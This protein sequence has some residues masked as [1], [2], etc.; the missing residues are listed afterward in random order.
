MTYPD[1]DPAPEAAHHE[2]RAALQTAIER[3]IAQQKAAQ[4]KLDGLNAQRESLRE[5]AARGESVTTDSLRQAE[6]KIRTAETDLL[7]HEDILRRQR[8]MVAD[9]DKV[10]G[11]ARAMAHHPRVLHA[12]PE[13]VAGTNEEQAHLVA[14]RAARK[15][16][17]EAKQVLALA[18]G[19]G[20]PVP[21]ELMP[22]P[23]MIHSGLRLPD[24]CDE[25]TVR[26]IF[27]D[28]ATEALG[29]VP[30]AQAVA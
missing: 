15:R 21:L 20:Y 6:A 7:N 25:R 26:R 3:T 17:D 10:A 5:A 8:A 9:H 1:F 16:V 2:Q 4:E 13:L 14:A 12:V 18:W 27:G 29:P 24:V 22:K 11:K 23:G 28:L 30:A 19:A